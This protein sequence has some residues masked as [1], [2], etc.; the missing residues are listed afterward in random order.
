MRAYLDHASTTP[1]RPA[2]RLAMLEWLERTAGRDRGAWDP[3]RVH[4][5]GDPSRIHAEGLAARVTLE[6]AR[7]RVAHAL[8]ARPRE[9]IF[10]S[11]ATESIAAACWGA[12]EGRGRHSVLAPVE[13]SAVREWAA[14]GSET[15]VEVDRLGRLDVDAVGDAVRPDTGLVHCQ[16][17]NHE[18]GTRQPV[19]AVVAAVAGRAL[20][21]VDAAQAA[22]RAEIEFDESGVD[23]MSVSSHKLGGPTGVG[24]LL[25]RRGLRLPPLL[26]G[27]DQERARRAGMENVAGIVGFAAALDESLAQLDVEPDRERR[28]TGLVVD[29]ANDTEGV[30]VL[31]DPVDRLP[32]IVC[33]G[34][35]GIEP[36]PVLLGLDAAGVAVHSGSSCSSEALEPS[37]VLAAMGVDAERSLRVSVGWSTTV[38]DVH[39]FLDALVEVLEQLRSLRRSG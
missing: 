36:Q 24:A 11:G 33:L 21:H 31:G 38:E 4:V 37:A 22:G 39:R 12:A 26:V 15:L 35:E 32:H 16:W 19:D 17:G 13:H 6:E 8:G 18:V 25:V 10:T 34:I 1:L 9:V 29:W 7:G 3:T 27:G 28:L 30:S 20:V 2:A 23:L 5:A 14:R